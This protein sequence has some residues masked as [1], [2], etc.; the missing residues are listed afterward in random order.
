MITIKDIAKEANVS[1]GTVDRVLH[2]RGGVSKKTE[3]KI[4][5]ILEKHNFS[6]N[7]VASALALKNKFYIAALI[8]GYNND[9]LFWKSPYLGILKATEDVKNFGTQVD[10]FKYNQYDSASYLE[11]FKKLIKTEPSAV[12][13][14]PTFLNE[15]TEIVKSLEQLEIPYFFLNVDLEGFKNTAFIGQDSYTAGYIAGKLM[16]LNISKS[17]SFLIIQSRRNI[18]KNNA[19]FKRIEG[20]NDFFIKNNINSQSFTL[21]IENLTNLLETKEKINDYLKQHPEIEGVFVPSS[22]IYLIADCLEDP[23][24]KKLQLIGFDNTPQNIDCLLNDSV[25]FLISQ[26]PFDQG[27]ESIRIIADYLIKNKTPNNKTFLPIEILLKE[28][29]IYVDRHEE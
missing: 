8:P 2:N 4:R 5:T 12:L 21:K 3:A 11:M 19:I 17:S 26:K 18:T 16:Y 10:T 22:R 6:V 28:N 29:A 9:D 1:D 14:V 13:L 23:Y 25:S 15:T 27:Y 20:F 7:P 24:L